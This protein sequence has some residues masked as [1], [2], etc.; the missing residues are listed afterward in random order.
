M[1]TNNNTSKI[2]PELPKPYHPAFGTLEQDVDL[3]IAML[4]AESETG[5]YEPVGPVATIK[6][7]IDTA[8]DDFA[9]RL[10]ALDHNGDPM[11][12]EVYK[13]WARNYDGDYA[14]AFE[15]R[16]EDGVL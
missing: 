12:V 15:I 16:E 11:H 2:N 6:E 3:G 14:I 9:R 13:V 5:Q 4:I 10:D 7:A 1:E 8:R